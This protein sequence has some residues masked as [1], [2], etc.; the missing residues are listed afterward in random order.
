MPQQVV[1]LGAGGHAKVVIEILR[2]MGTWQIVGL[3]DSKSG[4]WGTKVFEIPVLGDDAL[5]PQVRSQGVGFAFIGV[6]SVGDASVRRRIY[7]AVR[8]NGFQVVRAIHPSAVVSA[9]SQMGEGVTLM[10]GAVV[11]ASARLGNNV[12]I[13]TG[14]IVE[15]DC[16]IE[17]HAH[18]ATGARLAGAVR[19][20]GAAHVGAGAVVRES[21]AI[22]QGAI[23]GA[24]AV[25]VKDVEPWTVVV[26]NPA[27]VL[28]RAQATG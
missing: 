12:L 22:G 3:L 17:D 7:E 16:V 19:V 21:L 1:G 25:V 27:R 15:H 11:N 24:G 26:G 8:Q 9:S 28:Q 14:A 23:V 4:L 10:A 5:L 13:N 20:G 18:L 6:G 2:A